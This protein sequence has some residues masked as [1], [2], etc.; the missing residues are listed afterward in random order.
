M[1]GRNQSSGKAGLGVDIIIIILLVENYMAANTFYVFESV[2]VH[3]FV[4]AGGVLN[5][6]QAWKQR[7][8]QWGSFPFRTSRSFRGCSASLERMCWM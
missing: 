5:A 3:V 2:S 8:K 7:V 4:Y 1:E 6:P